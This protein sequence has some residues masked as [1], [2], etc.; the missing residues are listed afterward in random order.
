MQAASTFRLT[1]CLRC[2]LRLIQ[3][4]NSVTIPAR[5]TWSILYRQYGLAA[6][7]KKKRPRSSTY[8]PLGKFRGN[9]SDIVRENSVK[10]ENQSLGQ[11][12]EVIILRSSPLKSPNVQDN[13]D[14]L[15]GETVSATDLLESIDAEQVIVRNDEVKQNIDRL[16]S[17]K[18]RAILSRDDFNEL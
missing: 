15:D 14:G 5:S 9:D 2:Q 18:S 7:D 10:L 13:V 16:R 11:D 12:A 6:Y 17:L 8:R 3:S 4:R 1:V